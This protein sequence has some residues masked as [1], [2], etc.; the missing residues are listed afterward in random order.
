[1]VDLEKS[2]FYQCDKGV[3][4]LLRLQP[5][6]SRAGV[7]GVTALA[8]GRIGLQARVGAPPEGGKANAALIKLLAKAWRVPKSSISI[9]GGSRD[10]LKTLQVSGDPGELLPRLG[11]WA[12]GLGGGLEAG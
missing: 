3:R 2:P 6:A 7:D 11:A 1:M 10:R 5:G 12:R 4:V 9:V 8:D